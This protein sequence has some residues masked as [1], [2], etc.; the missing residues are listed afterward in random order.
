LQNKH[1]ATNSVSP[2]GLPHSLNFAVRIPLHCGVADA[3]PFADPP[4]LSS[5]GPRKEQEETELLLDYEEGARA[6]PSSLNCA[7]S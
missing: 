7:A 6:T 1:P 2:S 3:V 4:G 5:Q